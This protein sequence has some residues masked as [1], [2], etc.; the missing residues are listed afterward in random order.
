[1]LRF[2]DWPQI[3]E[4]RGFLR[5]MGLDTPRD[6]WKEPDHSQGTGQA[7]MQHHMDRQRVFALT[8]LSPSSPLTPTHRCS[9]A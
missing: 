1:M 2:P 4:P 8:G 5:P 7:V 3:H 6:P 9:D